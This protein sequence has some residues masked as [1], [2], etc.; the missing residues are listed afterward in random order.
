[1]AAASGPRPVPSPSASPTTGGASSSSTMIRAF[2][3]VEWQAAKK[4]L[5]DRDLPCSDFAVGLFLTV[6]EAM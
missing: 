5:R 2:T 4:K 1:M 3:G 6:K